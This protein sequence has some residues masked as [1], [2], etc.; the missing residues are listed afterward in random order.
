MEGGGGAEEDL[1][2]WEYECY[3]EFE[4]EEEFKCKESTIR[5]ALEEGG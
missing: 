5:A 1:V 3:L 2:G 4:L